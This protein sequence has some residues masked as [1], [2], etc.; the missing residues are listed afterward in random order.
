MDN[1]LPSLVNKY[2]LN[3]GIF[4]AAVYLV[5]KVGDDV[6]LGEGV[7]CG[8]TGVLVHRHEHRLLQAQP[9]QVCH[10]PS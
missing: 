1:S 9:R 7:G 3:V 6:R 8:V 5:L 10:T 2:G 4:S